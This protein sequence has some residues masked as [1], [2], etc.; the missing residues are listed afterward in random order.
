VIL[1]RYS[2]ALSR[3]V[4]EVGCGA[5]RMLGYLVELGGEVHGFDLAPEMVQYSRR[6]FPEAR[7]RVGDLRV[8]ESYPPGPFDAV[9]AIDNV[10][11]ILGDSERRQVLAGIRGL[12]APSG[13]LIFSSHNLA[14]LDGGPGPRDRRALRAEI[15]STL[16]NRPPA[17]M[18]R[19]AL[20]MP[21]RIRNRRRLAPLEQRASDHAIINDRAQSHGL[22]H[23]YI[24]REDQ[25]HQL[26]ELGFE[27]LECR[28]LE[29]RS[30]VEGDAA[31]SPHLQYV[32]T[33]FQ[34]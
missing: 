7:V 14:H 20:S 33:P 9:L 15:F 18:V 28:D 25:Q 27:L 1:A 12:L 4:V 30:V 32:A 17:W 34:S 5:G 13:L 19:T 21:R 26:A 6:R 29:G 3:R 11:D 24:G 23:Y 16:A 10:L 2:E 31:S 8:L 22:L